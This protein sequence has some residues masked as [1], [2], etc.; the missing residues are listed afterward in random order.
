MAKLSDKLFT[1]SFRGVPFKVEE[2]NRTAGRRTQVHEYPQ[3]D[4]PYVE[5][6][7]RATR[8]FNITAFVVGADYVDLADALL[9]ECEKPGPGQLIHPWLGALDVTLKEPARA[10]Y[11]KALG[12]VTIE[13]SFIESGALVFPSAVEDTTSQLQIAADDIEVAAEKN[14]LEK[15]TIAGLPDFV[16]ATAAV[17]IN[18]I[19]SAIALPKI[20]GLAVLKF[21]NTALS[22]I[23]SLQLLVADPAAL[24]AKFAALLGM[25]NIVG[26]V[27]TG[28]DLVQAI[29]KLANHKNLATVSTPAN[30]P[31]A[32]VQEYKN[33]NALNTLTRLTLLAQAVGL[34]SIIPAV[35]HDDTVKLRDNLI[36]S[37][38][39]EAETAS[40]DVY[41]ALTTARAKV[42]ADLTARAKDSA[43]LATITPAEVMPMLAIAYDYY[44]DATL[45]AEII[46]RNKVRHPLFVPVA[47]LKVVAAA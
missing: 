40:D 39:A 5:D 22:S 42:W 24:R 14:F 10:S 43:R 2:G 28:I 6:L 4:D 36:A 8:E 44:A 16:A 37:L 47:A 7:G 11:S 38:N 29:T 46:S 33:T 35:V 32:V 18:K 30:A 12:Q 3:R 1:A 26:Q 27:T 41:Q 15:Y 45:D 9:A 34:S 17:D 23:R 21:A 13:L 25:T 31:A 20:P 19:F